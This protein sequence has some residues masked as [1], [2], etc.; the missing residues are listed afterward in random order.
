MIFL[1]FSLKK[2]GF[3]YFFSSNCMLPQDYSSNSVSKFFQQ[4]QKTYF[5]LCLNFMMSKPLF[6]AIFCLPT[7]LI[8][9]QH[10]VTLYGI[11]WPQIFF[12]RILP[13]HET[14]CS[15]TLL[16]CSIFIHSF[17]LSLFL[18]FHVIFEYAFCLHVRS[19]FGAKFIVTFYYLFLIVKWSKMKIMPKFFEK[20]FFFRMLIL[21]SC[22]FHCQYKAKKMCK[23]N[24]NNKIWYVIYIIKD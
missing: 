23:K 4:L 8:S 21:V 22:V 20:E 2:F 7:I 12:I 5:I 19:F 1:S 18:Q 14:K 16:R 15:M 10:A 6:H 13:S 3:V 17:I 24:S 11:G 9:A